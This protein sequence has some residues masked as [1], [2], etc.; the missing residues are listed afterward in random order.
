MRKKKIFI[1][2][3]ICIVITLLAVLISSFFNVQLTL[4]KKPGTNTPLINTDSVVGR[5]VK[6]ELDNIIVNGSLTSLYISGNHDFSVKV[7]QNTEIEKR[8]IPIP[9]LFK[10]SVQ[11]NKVAFNTLQSG[12]DV[13]VYGYRTDKSFQIDATKIEILPPPNAIQGTITN[14]QN[15]KISMRGKPFPSLGAVNSV[16]K[17]YNV[18]INTETE[19]S[20]YLPLSTEDP[21]LPPEKKKITVSDLKKDMKIVIYTDVDV[22][23]HQ[24]FS[25]FRIDPQM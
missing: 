1:I 16:L 20:Y 25:A 13:V 8:P 5:I 12:Q 18:D 10:K 21:S 19:I 24:T 2:L 23:T 7:Y 6:K 22:N 9:Y 3:L 14:I 11:S 17:S 15:N 4:K